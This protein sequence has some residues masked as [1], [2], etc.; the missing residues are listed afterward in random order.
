MAF[1]DWSE[2]M[3]VGNLAI[4]HDHQ[5]IVQMINLLHDHINSSQDR[6]TVGNTLNSLIDYTVYHFEREE[7]VMA[8]CNYPALDEHVHQHE[9]LKTQVADIADRFH[10]HKE[11]V[12]HQQLMEF[13]KNW[14]IN[15]IL[16]EDMGF[17]P[18]AEN[19]PEVA[20]LTPILLEDANQPHL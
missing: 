16:K 6:E 15:H 4:D 3:S 12:V 5:V 10:T 11:E 19:H 14:L 18:Y 9:L 8:A 17:R 20:K 13:L 1:I 2:S 7:Q